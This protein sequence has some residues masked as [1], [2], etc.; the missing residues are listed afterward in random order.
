MVPFGVGL[1]VV[2]VVTMGF[3]V[4]FV[5]TMGFMVVFVVTMGFMVVFVVTMGFLVVF[6]VTTGFFVVFFVVGVVAFFVVGPLYPPSKTIDFFCKIKTRMLTLLTDIYLSPKQEV[7]SLH[8]A[9][10]E[11]TWSDG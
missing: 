11:H 3:L 7:V 10:K 6:V 9:L 1:F 2:F 5:V 8:I 4:V